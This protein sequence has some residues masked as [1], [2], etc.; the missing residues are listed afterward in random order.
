MS[1]AETAELVRSTG[2]WLSTLDTHLA[3]LP[4]TMDGPISTT[5]FGHPVRQSTLEIDWAPGLY[6][7]RIDIGAY[8][9]QSVTIVVDT[10]VDEDDGDYSAGDLSFREA[11]RISNAT[12]ER[13][14]IAFATGLAAAQDQQRSCFQ[15]E[16]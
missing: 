2:Y 15:R 11:I 3:V 9:E 12:L 5:I 14:T 4:S 6:G 13:D 7:G 10:V 8:E 1:R 16:S